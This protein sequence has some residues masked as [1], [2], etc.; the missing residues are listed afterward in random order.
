MRRFDA[1]RFIDGAGGDRCGFAGRTTGQN[2]STKDREGDHR[3]STD[4]ACASFY[5]VVMLAHHIS[6]L[7]VARYAPLSHCRRVVVLLRRV[8]PV[9]LDK[10]FVDAAP[11]PSRFSAWSVAFDRR[12]EGC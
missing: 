3:H 9:C 7:M 11:R 6:F 10:A 8:C 5:D 4:L 2:K 1:V 12:E